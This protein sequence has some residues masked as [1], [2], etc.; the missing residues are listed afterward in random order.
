MPK[1]QD[2]TLNKYAPFTPADLEEHGVTIPAP[3]PTATSVPNPWQPTS[4]GAAPAAPQAADSADSAS[5]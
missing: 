3:T 2:K 5:D 1:N 4:N